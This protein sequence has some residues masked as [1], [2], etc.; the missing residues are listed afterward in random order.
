MHILFKEVELLGKST[1]FQ[2]KDILIIM[3]LVN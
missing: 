2:I 3:V 1:F